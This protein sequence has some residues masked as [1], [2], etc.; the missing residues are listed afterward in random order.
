MLHYA[1]DVEAHDPRRYLR[2]TPIHS[3]LPEA[4]AALGHDVHLVHQFPVEHTFSAR[5][6]RYHFV[7]ERRATQRLALVG[8]T[9]RQRD[10]ALYEPALRTIERVRA[11]EPDILH[12]HGTTLNL[13]LHLLFQRLGREAPPA[14]LH[15]QGGYPAHSTFG[16]R[17]QRFNF[18]H[19]QRCAFTTRE[20]AHAFIEAGV[21]AEPR[22]IVSLI[23]TSSTFRMQDRES[24]RRET[25]MTGEPVC[26][27]VGR[28]HP[29]KDPLTM[30]R[31]FEGILAERSQAQIYL[32]YLTDEE[33]PALQRY[34]SDR[35]ALSEHVHFRGR[36]PFEQMEAIYNSADFLLQASRREFSGCAVLEAMAC[37]VIPIVSDIPSFRV[38]T[39]CGKAGS[40]FPIGDA[41]ALARSVT[42]IPLDQIG[43]RAR[44]VH[45]HFESKLSFEAMATQLVPL[46]REMLVER[47]C[48][49]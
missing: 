36:A 10:P 44:A 3:A 27:S 8:G 33:R 21:L 16:K 39:D 23:E 37:G 11:L 7:A 15:Y 2:E 24:A 19:A 30:L 34:L 18:A 9:L 47:A 12:L 31:G 17:L 25:G 38:M 20:Q 46:Y 42:H 40:L 35:P 26:L 6:V 32:Y 49:R 4:L 5:G 13:N 1:R 43:A 48:V 41:A 29:I 14:I 28:L 45:A 22:R